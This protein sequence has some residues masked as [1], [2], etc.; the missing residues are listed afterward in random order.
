TSRLLLRRDRFKVAVHLFLIIGRR[1]VLDAR[2]EPVLELLH[3]E[4]GCERRFRSIQGRRG[5]PPQLFPPGEILLEC[6][7]PGGGQRHPLPFEREPDAAASEGRI[8][9]PQLV[10]QIARFLELP[11]VFLAQARQIVAACASLSALPASGPPIVAG[12][13]FLTAAPVRRLTAGG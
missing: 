4:S 13:R 6:L 8:V 12:T 10:E 9:T 1:F 7:G 11:R 5:L 2:G 3:L